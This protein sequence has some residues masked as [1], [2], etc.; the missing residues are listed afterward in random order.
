MTDFLIYIYIYILQRQRNP[1]L[2]S[3]HS[4]PLLSDER[5]GN[6]T[7]DFKLQVSLDSFILYYNLSFRLHRWAN[8]L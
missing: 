6:N 5:N 1:V 7:F 2:R 8:S 4:E 3:L